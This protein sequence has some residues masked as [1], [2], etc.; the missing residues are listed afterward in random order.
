MT[1]CFLAGAYIHGRIT[2]DN[3][4]RACFVGYLHSANTYLRPIEDS[5]Y[6]KIFEDGLDYCDKEYNEKN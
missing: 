2:E 4:K 6:D 1:F 3:D 5:K